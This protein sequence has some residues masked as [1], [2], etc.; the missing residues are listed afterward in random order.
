MRLCK[1]QSWDQ[2]Y[3]LLLVAKF[4]TQQEDNT[5]KAGGKKICEIWK[6]PLLLW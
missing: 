4:G 2:N 1:M 6:Q 5:D 3:I